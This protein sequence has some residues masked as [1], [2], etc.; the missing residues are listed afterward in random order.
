MDLELDPISSTAKIDMNP[1]E[2]ANLNLALMTCLGVSAT[3]GNHQLPSST[4]TRIREMLDPVNARHLSIIVPAPSYLDTIDYA[5]GTLIDDIKATEGEVT[6]LN[7]MQRK[8]REALNIA[9]PNND[10]VT[11]D[12]IMSFFASQPPNEA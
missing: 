2:R 5:L 7:S 1:A 12:M 9:L 3:E 4:T 11:D 10:L 8:I 6:E